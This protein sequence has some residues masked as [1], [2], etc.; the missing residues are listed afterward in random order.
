MFCNFACS[1]LSE[2]LHLFF[3]Y[4]RRYSIGGVRSVLSRDSTI[5]NSLLAFAISALKLMYISNTVLV[6]IRLTLLRIDRGVCEI[7]EY[8]FSVRSCCPLVCWIITVTRMNHEM[9]SFFLSNQPTETPNNSEHINIKQIIIPRFSRYRSSLTVY[10]LSFIFLSIIR[11]L[12][13]PYS[14]Y[15]LAIYKRFSSPFV[16]PQCV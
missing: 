2:P 13:I 8:H 6:N 15:F 9:C 5:K 7:S 1:F 3:S 12:T 16:S 11:V 14:Q 4:G 10:A